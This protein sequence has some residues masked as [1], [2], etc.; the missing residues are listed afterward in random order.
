MSVASGACLDWQF[1][2]RRMMGAEEMEEWTE[3]QSLP[4]E[5]GLFKYGRG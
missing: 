5:V 2:L 3:L 1:R 4:N